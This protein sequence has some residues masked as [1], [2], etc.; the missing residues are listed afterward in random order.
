MKESFE[1]HF[2]L[3][4]GEGGFST[5]S[6][7]PSDLELFRNVVISHYRNALL[8]SGFEDE[9]GLN[10]PIDSYHQLSQKLDHVVIWETKNRVLTEEELETFLSADFFKDMKEQ[11]GEIS[12]SDEVGIGHPAI[13][14]RLV[15]PTPF[16]DVGPL[17]VDK[18]FWDLENIYSPKGYKRVKF[19]FSLWNEQGLSGLRYVKGSHTQEYEYVGE[20]RY[21]RMKP[22]FDEKKYDLEITPFCSKPG[23]FLVFNDSLLHGG[24]IGGGNTRV[25]FEFTLFI[26]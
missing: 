5:D 23:D 1:T 20:K 24:M 14:L 9:A 18:W 26:K 12:I 2:Q 15:R 10:Q 17:H 3:V 7:S 19:W 6:V 8:N 16:Y 21:G 11:I 4:E 22:C 13:Y 25:S